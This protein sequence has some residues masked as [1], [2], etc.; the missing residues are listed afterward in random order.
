MEGYFRC[1]M[2]NV[3]ATRKRFIQI[4]VLC[5][6]LWLLAGWVPQSV[7]GQSTTFLAIK[8][9]DVEV[10]LGNQ[11]LLNLEV[12]GGV[13]VNAFD[14]MVNYDI[15][16]LSLV[17][18]E[19]GDY[20]KS[21]SC[22]HE[23]NQPGVLELACT[24]IAQQAV[25]GDGVLLE[26]VFDSLAVGVG[27]VTITEAEFADLT[28]AKLFPDRQHGEVT[29]SD[30]PT[31]TPTA[32][33]TVTPTPTLTPTPTVTWTRTSTPLMTGTK[34]QTK[35]AN[36]TATQTLTGV[37]TQGR[38]VEANPTG[39][40][41]TVVQAEESSLLTETSSGQFIQVTPKPSAEM[42]G[43]VPTE[44]RGTTISEAGAVTLDTTISVEEVV[45]EPSH[46]SLWNWVLWLVLVSTVVTLVVMIVV[47]IN[48]RKSQEEDLLL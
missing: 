24:Q 47:F 38:T 6:F 26:L 11:V 10:P 23:V 8:P 31:Y 22:L 14:I 36:F 35:T 39:M 7:G 9:E 44:V 16:H 34:T 40:T 20:L 25:S 19:H 18:W 48:R 5:A 12:T 21:L 32:T 4:G 42:V 43:V 45:E 33:R 28:G 13:N 27:D 2:L 17:S 46:Q 1:G 41:N 29:I 30:D 3:M 15:Q 37:V